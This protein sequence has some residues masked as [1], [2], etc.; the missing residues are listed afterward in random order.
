LHNHEEKKVSMTLSMPEDSTL[1]PLEQGALLVSRSF[2]V[3][4]FVPKKS[5]SAVKRV[6]A[7]KT[8]ISALDPSLSAE[9]ARHGF[10]GKPRQAAPAEPTV[11]FQLT[12]RCDLA[13]EY[14][15]T[16]SGEKRAVELCFEDWRHLTDEALRVERRPIIF[17]LLGGEPFLSPCAVPVSRYIQSKGAALTIFT[18]GIAL[19]DEAC[20]DEVADLI[21]NGAKIRISMAGPEKKSCDRLSGN[22]RFEPALKGIF[23]LAKRGAA[24]SVDMMVFPQ[25]V[26]DIARH[27]DE[28]QTMLPRG[29]VVSFGIAYCGG[30]EQGAHMFDTRKDLEAA[31]DRIAL[32]SGTAIPPPARS[33]TAPRREAC[34]CAFGHDMHIR[35]DGMMFN[36]FKMEEPLGIYPQMSLEAAWRLAKTRCTPAPL[37]DA[38][39]TCP[40]ATLCG[41]GCRSEN[42]LYTKKGDVP[43]C[44]PW[45]KQVIS[46]MLAE[47]NVKVLE[48]PTLYLV[49]EAK[50]RGLD[51][52]VEASPKFRSLNVNGLR[53][54]Q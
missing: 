21:R 15:C 6:L 36:C 28:F 42:I 53:K 31:M 30:R 27:F 45:R 10:F 26:S 32:E 54:G 39:E 51:A 5:A 19:A 47:D 2:A 3:F 13:C 17:S 1:I 50:R 11:R 29:T 40:L 4:C 25:T 12:N 18:N 49:N 20:A 7:G 48:W 16:D 44:G 52:P 43:M 35:S 9:L 46:E 8:D 23:N 37:L 33:P 24:V 34:R 41:G 22:K 38:C 14:C